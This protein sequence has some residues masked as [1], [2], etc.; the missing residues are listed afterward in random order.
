MASLRE[1]DGTYCHWGLACLHGE[2][3][4]HEALAEVHE[5]LVQEVLFSPPSER[6]EDLEREAKNRGASA[7]EY[8]SDLSRR[9]PELVPARLGKLSRRV[10]NSVLPALSALVQ[11]TPHTP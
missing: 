10:F 4:V 7:G 9:S 2:R 6:L 5:G 8:L 11:A 1:P 3:A